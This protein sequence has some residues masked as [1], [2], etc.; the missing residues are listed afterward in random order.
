MKNAKAVAWA[1]L[2][3]AAGVVDAAAQGAGPYFLNVDAKDYPLHVRFP[4]PPRFAY[5]AGI[6]TM[7]DLDWESLSGAVATDGSGKIAGL[8][9]A[10][11]YFGGP[12]NHVTDY[13]AFSVTVTGS[14]TDKNNNPRVKVTLKGHGYDFDG[15]SNHPNA[16][17]SLKFTSTNKLV[18]VPSLVITNGD[19]VRTNSAFTYLSGK[20]TGNIEPGKHSKVNDGN[21]I[22][23]HTTG[24]LV[25]DGSVWTI[26]NGTNFTEKKLS[27]SLVLDVLGNIDAQV[28]QPVSGSKLYLNANVGSLSNL[29]SATGT[30]TYS[31]SR[32]N[33]SFAGIAFGRG[34]R[35]QAKG[36]LG[37]LIVAYDPAPD[38]PT[39]C[40]GLCR[41][42]SGT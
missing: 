18:F 38:V 3:A 13:G 22:D 6:P 40:P 21:K 26:V 15:L 29:F 27:G 16:T 41:T 5:T 10:R 28:I 9:Y 34:L 32:W 12:N 42:P 2:I 11:I 14:T 17:L 4:D 30:A 1:L 31:S 7:S 20:V 37:P 8:V 33:A 25:T 19:V 23:V 24:M 35:L 39:T 36:D